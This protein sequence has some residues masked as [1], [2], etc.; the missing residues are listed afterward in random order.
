MLMFRNRSDFSRS[1]EKKSP[2]FI[3]QDCFT[4]S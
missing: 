4:K 1:E 2:V 3:A